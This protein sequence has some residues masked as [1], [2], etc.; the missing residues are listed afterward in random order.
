MVLLSGSGTS[1]CIPFLHLFRRKTALWVDGKAWT[2][3]KWGRLARAFL[4][5]SA[6]FGV[7]H[8]DAMVTDTPLA[9]EFYL[10]EMGRDTTYIPYGANI[11]EVESTETLDRLGL[12]PGNYL[13]FVGR[14]IPEKGV[15]YLI[16]AFEKLETDCRLVI[17]GDDP[18]DPEFVNALKQTNDERIMFTGYIFGEG[19]QQLMRHCRVYVQPSDVEGTSPVLLTAMGFGRPVVVNGI[20]ENRTTIGEAGLAFSR[21]VVG[22]LRRILGEIL[23]DPERLAEL[24]K[25]AVARVR[26]HYDWD[27]ITTDFERL[28][29]DQMGED[30]GEVSRV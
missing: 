29:R 13:L 3:G 25:A 28:F 24:G 10:K 12:V 16:D 8:S 5:R 14:L 21:G 6:Q 19:F 2:R 9:H 1:F 30:V 11:E 23:D 17:V 27:K 7:R 20:P 15:H 22:D 18:Y 4:Q 26:S